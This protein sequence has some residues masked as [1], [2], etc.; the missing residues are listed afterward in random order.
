MGILLTLVFLFS[1]FL[2]GCKTA[3]P[4][5]YNL[6]IT[7]KDADG[8]PVEGAEVNLGEGDYVTDSKGVVSV[9]GLTETEVYVYI[10]KDGY[11]SIEELID[12]KADNK[13]SYILKKLED[14]EPSKSEDSLLG[15][16]SLNSYSYIMKIGI[17]KNE[18][19]T[20]I[21]GFKEKPDKLRLKWTTIEGNETTEIITVGDKGNMKLP[22]MD[23]WIDM[24]GGY[25]DPFGQLLIGQGEFARNSFSDNVTYNVDKLGSETILGLPVVKYRITGKSKENKTDFYVWVVTS[26]D[27]KNLAVKSEDFSPGLSDSYYILIELKSMNK[28]LNIKLP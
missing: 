11:E 7:V 17:S 25:G 16:D 21:E 27:F 3:Q 22:G 6:S 8:K 5:T 2:T 4:T 13:V 10:A 20:E 26:G 18:I 1:V 28:P 12:L 9:K 15:F 23:E 14:V 24:P 19:E